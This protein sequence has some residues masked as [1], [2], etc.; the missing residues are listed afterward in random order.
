MLG[1]KQI[2][3]VGKVIPVY[4]EFAGRGQIEISTTP[5]YHPILPLICDSQI[6]DVSH[7]YVP[8]PAGFAIREDARA[9][10]RDGAQVHGDTDR[11][12]PGGLVAV[13]GLGLR[14]SP[15][16]GSQRRG[17]SGLRPTTACS[18]GRCN[19]IPRPRSTYRPYLWK[20]G[21]HQMHGIF[22]DHYLSDL[23]GFVYSR[24]GAA[25]PPTHFLDRIRDNCRP[26][27]HSGRDALVPIIL[28]G[29]NAW[30]YYEHGGR[31]FLRELYRRITD[32]PDM[33]ALT[34]SEALARMGSPGARRHLP[35]FVDQRQLRCLDRRRR[36]QQSL[37]VPAARAPDL[38]SRVA[39]RLK[40]HAIPEDREEACVRRT[41]DRR[42]QRLELVVRSGARFG[43][44]SGVRP[45]IPR[46]PGQRVHALGLIAA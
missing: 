38:R 10:T 28:D 19:G 22:R 29:E 34:V 37:G 43:E 17:S 16:S 13:R 42:R 40:A 35:G 14:R 25:E 8:L 4:R 45:A 6:A 46:S 36:G 41:A 21:G 31:P 27:L 30:E 23:I 39:H 15:A 1:R 9:S 7:P 12:A 3:V 44:P 26:I 2:E 32:D 24:M 18:A 11:P 5:F 33:T 20:Q